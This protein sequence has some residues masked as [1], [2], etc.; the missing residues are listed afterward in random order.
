MNDFLKEFQVLANKWNKMKK[1]SKW[2]YNSFNCSHL[3]KTFSGL[4]QQST[5]RMCH[6][7]PLWTTS[8]KS[9][10]PGAKSRCVLRTQSNIQEGAF[11]RK[12]PVAFSSEE[13][14]IVR[15]QQVCKREN[16]PLLPRCNSAFLFA[17][18]R[19]VLNLKMSCAVEAKT[20]KC[21]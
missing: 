11:L 4:Q 13:Y 9:F 14:L 18:G 15:F 20:V 21:V 5:K 2:K 17:A 12:Y 16:I 8:G 6:Y 10:S 1:K 3:L 19:Y 7:S